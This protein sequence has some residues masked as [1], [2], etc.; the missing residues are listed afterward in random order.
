ME[1]IKTGD[2][3]QVIVSGYGGRR[4]FDLA[5]ELLFADQTASHYQVK[6][7]DRSSSAFLDKKVTPLFEDQHPCMIF[8]WYADKGTTP[9]PY[10]MTF[11]ECADLAWGWLQ[12]QDYKD[13]PD[14]DGSNSRGWAVFNESW[15]HVDNSHYAVG[16]VS[17]QW[18]W[19]GK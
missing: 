5:M 2:N 13:E 12:Q 19:I 14:H 10:K 1:R 8:Y 16:A 11:K 18:I 15:G 17:P 4:A 7:I 3:S 6:I 9:L